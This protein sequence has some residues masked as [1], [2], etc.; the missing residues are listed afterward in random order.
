[1][2]MNRGFNEIITLIRSSF[3]GEANIHNAILP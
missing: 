1:M 3:N 2:L